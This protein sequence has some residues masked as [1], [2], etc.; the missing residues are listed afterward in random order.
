MA[1]QLHHHVVFAIMA[2]PALERV[3]DSNFGSEP[4]A[5]KATLAH[6]RYIQSHP[7]G[8]RWP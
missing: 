7:I 3:D 6:A 8:P 1:S 2:G 4:A 5:A